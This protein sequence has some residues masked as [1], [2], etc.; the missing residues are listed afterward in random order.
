MPVAPRT[1]PL[2]TV[3]VVDDDASFLAAV[4]RLLR[5]MGHPVKAFS[6][7]PEFLHSLP[8]A[9]PGCVVADVQMP[10]LSGLELQA[11]LTKTDNPLPV[12]FLTGHGDIPTSVRAMRQGAEDFLTKNAPKEELMQ[13]V[14]RALARD[15]RERAERAR[16]QGLR[17]RFEALTGRDREVLQ[18]VLRGQLNKQI[19]ADLEIDERSVKRHRASIMAKLQVHSVAELT[20]LVHEAGMASVISNQ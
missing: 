15:A 10:G 3:F 12:L 16:V 8:D 14:K 13:A 7:A 17:A 1:S 9:G 4:S 19:A 11:A 5:A 20:R 18:H 6:S 2:P